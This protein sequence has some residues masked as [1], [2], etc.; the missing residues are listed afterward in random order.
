MM[1]R[2]LTMIAMVSFMAFSAQAAHFSKTAEGTPQLVQKGPQKMWCAVC[3]MNLKMFYK[4]SHAV[5]LD[6][7]TKKQ[8]CSIRCLAADWPNIKGHVKKILVVDAKTGKLIDAKSA[9]YVVGSK[10]KGTMSMTSK[11]AFGSLDDAKAFQ[12]TYGGKIIA[13]DEAFAMAKKALANESMMMTMKKEKKIYPMD[14]K[15]Y[16]K[17]CQPVD[18]SAF[19]HI[20]ELKAALKTKKLCKPLPEKQLQAVAL[21][22]WE[23]KGGHAPCP[24]A[25]KM[26]GK[27]GR[28]MSMHA[29]RMAAE[30]G[31]CK[32]GMKMAKK[33][34]ENEGPDLTK[35]DKCPVCGMFVYKHPKWA[36]FIYYEKNGK[37][38]HLAF[39]GVKD[40][41]KF[42]LNPNKWGDY[43]DIKNHIMKIVVRD[44]YTLKPILA[45][46]AWYVMGSDVLGP[47]GNE[48]IPFASREAA[49]N[50]MRDHH[51]KKIV[52]FDEI[53]E[54]LLNSLDA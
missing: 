18:P 10:V 17:M 32:C 33:A 29:D 54:S 5:E 39:D 37:M 1:K 15:I 46:R 45:K 16:K 53:D 3:G 2:W 13:F 6:D 51:G 36:A 7:G 19:K 49:E 26:D 8:Y 12:K 38:A 35:Q 44:Y 9:R 30:P 21:Y 28:G 42:Y 34:S 43:G 20:N 48:L 23:V 31:G 11:I 27:Q 25:A 4:T 24:C 14:E 40:L 41:M 22:L 52:R 47:M 50:F